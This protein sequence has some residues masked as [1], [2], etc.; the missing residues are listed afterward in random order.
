MLCFPADTWDSTFLGEETNL[1]SKW[2]FNLFFTNWLIH[3]HFHLFIIFIIIREYFLIGD[4]TFIHVS[5]CFRL[6]DLGSFLKFLW[7]LLWLSI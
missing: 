2:S 3:N 5:K 4:W 1:I 6:K 7:S